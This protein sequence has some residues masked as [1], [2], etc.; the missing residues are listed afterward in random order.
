VAAEAAIAVRAIRKAVA[1]RP[2]EMAENSFASIEKARLANGPSAAIEE[3]LRS[4]ESRGELHRLFDG[5]LLK[6]KFEMGLPVSRPTSFD[7]VPD[8]RQ[9]EFEEAYIAAARRV[10][11]AFLSQGNVPQAWIYLRTIREPER[12]TKALEEIAVDNGLPENVD[13]LISIALYERA[14]PV[15]GLELMLQSR[16]TCNTITAFD[17]AVPQISSEDRIRGAAMLVHHLSGELFQSVCRDIERRESAPCTCK[18]LIEAITERD[19]LFDDGNYHIDVSHLAAVVRFA[20]F[21]PPESADL[22]VVLQLCEYGKRL[23]AQFQFPADPPFDD[24]Y[25][26]HLRFFQILAN[27]H[28]DEAIAYFQDRIRSA[29]DLEDRRLIAYVLVDLLVRIDAKNDAVMVAKEFLA[30]L[31]ESSG[32][33]FAQLCEEA[34]RMDVFRETAQNKGDL[35]GFTAALLKEPSPQRM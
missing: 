18:S 9:G 13:E 4:L 32:F 21:L 17:Q 8:E 20:R 5:L 23:S 14:H 29:T 24:Y 31:D 26:A 30:D 28:R 19:W 2:A 35:V 10:G 22:P 3:L 15:K 16:G 7:N 6:K 27:V 34:E 1:A 25:T 11:E 33:S 12:V